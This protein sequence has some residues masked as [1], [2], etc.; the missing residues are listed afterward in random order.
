MPF[1]GGPSVRV[2]PNAKV[3]IRWIA[4]FGEDGRVDVAK[5]VAYD[6]D[7]PSCT[8]RRYRAGEG[9]V[10]PGD[11]HVH[12]L[13]NETDAETVAIQL[14]PQGA[15]RRIGASAPGNCPF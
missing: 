7:D 5:I 4:D 6:G 1:T 15:T 10:D 3:E 2:S 14:L 12:L 9:I 11:G 13:R 8:P